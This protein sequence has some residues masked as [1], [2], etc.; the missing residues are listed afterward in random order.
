MA[1]SIWT[2]NIPLD[3][4][5]MWQLTRWGIWQLREEGGGYADGQ[6]GD[7]RFWFRRDGGYT[8]NYRTPR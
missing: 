3:H 1:F 8:K 5:I 2:T 6:I 7:P 4:K